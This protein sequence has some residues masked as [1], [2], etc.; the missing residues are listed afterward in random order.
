VPLTLVPVLCPGVLVLSSSA[1]DAMIAVVVPD[2]NTTAVGPAGAAIMRARGLTCAG[3]GAS[4]GGAEASQNC[5][6]ENGVRA[7]VLIPAACAA[8]RICSCGTRR[9]DVVSCATRRAA[10]NAA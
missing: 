9:R 6:P 8:D 7:V 5:V 10:G 3:G 4:A 1:V 2:A